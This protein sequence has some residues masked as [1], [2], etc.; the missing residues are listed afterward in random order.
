MNTLEAH[1]LDQLIKQLQTDLSVLVSVI[2]RLTERR[3][4]LLRQAS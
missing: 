4:L 3:D 1:E 2:Q